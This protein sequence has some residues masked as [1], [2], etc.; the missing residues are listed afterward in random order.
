MLTPAIRA[1]Q[2]FSWYYRGL[3]R[4]S[5]ISD[6]LSNRAPEW[7]KAALPEVSLSKPAFMSV[8]ID[9]H[10]GWIPPAVNPLARLFGINGPSILS[11]SRLTPPLS[12]LPSTDR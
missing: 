1:T 7:H 12:A 9:G 11:T 4:K 3:R 2:S 6:K 10:V 8:Q 5:S